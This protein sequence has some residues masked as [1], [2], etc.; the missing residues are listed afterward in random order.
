MIHNFINKHFNDDKNLKQVL[1]RVFTTYDPDRTNVGDLTTNIS[2]HVNTVYKVYKDDGALLKSSD[3]VKTNYYRFNKLYANNRDN[4]KEAI[5]AQKKA[6][7][8]AEALKK[9][10]EEED[11]KKK[12]AEE[13]EEEAIAKKKAKEEA[14]KKA[15]QEAD[16]KAKE[17]A[18]KK[19]EE[20]KDAEEEK[21]ADKKAKEN[22]EESD[23]EEVSKINSGEKIEEE[24]DDEEV[25]KINSGEKIEEEINTNLM[26]I[27]KK[28][29]ME[30]VRSILNTTKIQKPIVKMDYG[31][32]A[33]EIYFCEK[34]SRKTVGI[35]NS[36]GLQCYANAS[37]QF[38]YSLPYYRKYYIEKTDKNNQPIA[39]LFNDID[40]TSNSYV[41]AEKGSINNITCPYIIHKMVN[42]NGTVMQEDVGEYMSTAGILNDIPQEPIVYTIQTEFTCFNKKT[43][44]LAKNEKGEDKNEN[45]LNLE[46]TSDTIAGCLDSYLNETK[47]YDDDDTTNIKKLIIENINKNIKDLKQFI[48]NNFNPKSNNPD[49]VLLSNLN[50]IATGKGDKEEITDTNILNKT[51]FEL[52]KNDDNT[53]N[54]DKFEKYKGYIIQQYYMY[55]NNKKW[56]NKQYS[57]YAN[58]YPTECSDYNLNKN[59]DN[60]KKN[61][62]VDNFISALNGIDY[63]VGVS[64]KKIEITIPPENRYIF[65]QIKRFDANLNK[66]KKKVVPD[67]TIEIGGVTYTLSGI[68]CHIGKYIKGGHYIYIQCNEKGDYYYIYNDTQSYPYNANGEFHEKF[69]NENGYLFSYSRYPVD[70]YNPE[71]TMEEIINLELEQLNQVNNM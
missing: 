3:T 4:A 54:K 1:H 17:E 69:I 7:E 51:V 66:E 12:K 38:L 58:E 32:Y 35:E 55:T 52:L 68:I 31:H 45:M 50:F 8:E 16:K 67:K 64:K 61:Y 36:T 14:D 2:G 42:L 33:D 49:G 41:E 60:S 56:K 37:I 39:K 48:N 22:E 19:A 11:A 26:T 28:T 40:T 23:D 10:A 70:Q 30:T 9:K 29:F 15:K 62:T 13:E 65:I 34:F 5:A 44:I 46:N 57:D 24:S 20:E 6:K 18:D 43:Y 25:S 27:A 71:K 63:L 59:Y 21:E 53:I 47:S